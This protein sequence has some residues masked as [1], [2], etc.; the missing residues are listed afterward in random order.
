VL[1]SSQDHL[2]TRTRDLDHPVSYR[3][4]N[5]DSW[6][7][8]KGYLRCSFPL[9]VPMV[10][11]SVLAIAADVECLS[12]GGFSISETICFGSLEFITDCFSGLSLSPRGDGLD[13]VTTGSTHS[14]PPC[15]LRAMI[16]DSI[17]E[18]RMALG[19]K[20]GSDPCLPEGMAPGLCLSPPR[21]RTLQP[22]RL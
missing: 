3:G 12:C 20:G 19:R 5:T 1:Y 6:H 2:G 13:A 16:G 22:P 17:E 9:D 4:K 14:G 8:R 7:A 11:S 15:L 18:F 21:R 10:P